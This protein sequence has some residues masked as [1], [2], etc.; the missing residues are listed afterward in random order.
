MNVA[1][2]TLV[3][4]RI[5]RHFGH[6]FGTLHLLFKLQ[7]FY[8]VVFKEIYFIN[9]YFLAFVHMDNHLIGIGKGWVWLFFDIYGYVFKTL[10]AIKFR[11]DFNNIS[12]NILRDD[13]LFGKTYF[14][15]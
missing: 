14:S 1:I 13:R 3:R 6:F 11:C 9:P 12:S 7:V 10:L 8:L 4:G 15:L 2:R 5:Q